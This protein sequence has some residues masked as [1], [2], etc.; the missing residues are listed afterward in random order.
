VTPDSPFK[1]LDPFGESDVDALLFFGREREREIV[2][3]NLIASRLTVLYGPTGVG[4]SSLLRAAVARSLRALPEAPLVVVFDR[5]GDDPAVDLRAAIAEAT[6][7]PAPP[8][9]HAAVESAQT[10]RDVYLILDQT[11]EYFVYHGDDGAF[12]SELARLVVE[13]LRVNVLL[14]LRED[15]LARLDQF[16]PRIPSVYA[17]SLRLDRLDRDAARA[18]IVGPVARWS[19]LAGERMDVEPALVEAVLDGVEAGHIEQAVGGLG[20]AESNGRPRSVE[21]PYLQLVMQ[22]VWDVERSAGSSLLRAE[23]LE[24]LGGARRVVADHLEVAVD[25]LSADQRDVAARLFTYLVTPSGTK[26]AHELPDLAEYAGVSEAEAAPVVETLSRHRI[27]R[28]DEAGRTEIFHDVLAGEVLAWRRHHAAESALVRERAESRRRHRRLA[29]LAGGA[30]LGFVLMAMLTVFALT[31]RS[32]A[33]D[34]AAMARAHELEALSAAAL[35]RDPELSLLLAREAARVA[36]S[37]TTE[38]ALRSALLESRVRTVVVVDEELLGAR[39]RGDDVL[40]AT[41]SGSVVVADARTGRVQR[42]LPGAGPSLSASFADDGGALFTGRDGRLRLVFLDGQVAPVPGLDGARRAEISQDGTRAA[43]VED[44]RVRLVDVETGAVEQTFA[45]RGARSAAISRDNLRVVTG[46]ED[47]TVRVWIARTGGLIRELPGNTGNVEAVAFSPDGSLVAAASTDGL[48]RVWRVGKGGP[49]T[50]PGDA[51]ALTDV[52]FS[53]DGAHVVIASRDGSVRVSKADSGVPLIVLD[54]HDGWVTSAEFTGAAGSFVVTASVDG[55]ARIWDAL[56][57]PQLAELARLP[58][59]VSGLA[60]DADGRLR[61]SVGRVAHVLDPDTGEVVRRERATKSSPRIDGPEG[62][63]ATIRGKTVVLRRAGEEKTLEGHR[64]RILAAGFSPDGSLLA[65]ASEDH[66]VRIWDT[67]S[68]ERIRT[69]EQ[70]SE[71]RDVS[72][73][74]DGRWLVTAAG[75]AVLWDP[76]TGTVIVRLQGHEGPFTA[77]RFDPTGRTIV[78]AGADGTVRAYDCEICGGL[79]ELVTLAE[80][81]LAVTARE[82]TPEERER[83]LG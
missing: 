53:L 22:R 2:V 60:F 35:N 28:P 59:P 46:S 26:I 77:A 4:K 51:T 65:T 62:M 78:T 3:A 68:G 37:E 55:T 73:S 17:N 30:L 16:K 1:G 79:D 69:L 64:N 10:V 50:I 42:T 20:A 45:H 39:L 66:D 41:T 8:D 31:Q 15:S 13:P 5:W 80:E 21:A 76:Q 23:T 43:V 38:E 70:N 7:D 18:A 27:L 33:R 40:A 9:L 75:R 47:E 36:P 34:Q 58:G 14:S 11:E 29:W 67:A 6:G 19:E 48:A 57:Q 56:V 81:R 32:N 61:A 72:F 49:I 24:T 12:D 71:I 74:P 83:Y 54:G 82:L 52:S 63:T 25:A 44:G